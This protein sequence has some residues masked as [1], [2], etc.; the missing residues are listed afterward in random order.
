MSARLA[1][2]LSFKNSLE[3]PVK[4]SECVLTAVWSIL[5]S[6]TEVC[7]EDN[8]VVFEPLRNIAGIALKM[9]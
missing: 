7:V 1:Q 4:V 8:V 2:V 5:T 3:A 6:S 9:S